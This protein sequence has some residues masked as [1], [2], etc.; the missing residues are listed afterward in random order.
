LR[1]IVRFDLLVVCGQIRVH[2][3]GG[4]FPPWTG[5]PLAQGFAWRGACTA[6]GIPDHDREVASVIRYRI[7]GCPRMLDFPAR[8]ADTPRNVEA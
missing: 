1:L 4:G 7:I 8:D 2:R 5:T 3:P 6:F